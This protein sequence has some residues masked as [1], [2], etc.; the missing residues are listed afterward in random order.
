MKNKDNPNWNK[1]IDH[2][3]DKHKPVDQQP[4]QEQ[5]QQHNEVTQTVDTISQ[6]K[7]DAVPA[8]AIAPKAERRNQRV[9]LVFKPSTHAKMTALAR[10]AGISM[11]NLVNSILE[12]YIE[13]HNL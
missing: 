10:A 7:L 6:G 1:A 4:V 3:F 13:Q 9:Q 12:D 5:P 8:R 11:N 2:L